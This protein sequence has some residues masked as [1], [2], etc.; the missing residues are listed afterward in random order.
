MAAGWRLSLRPRE[1]LSAINAFDGVS[2][3]KVK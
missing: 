3:R 1:A 2:R